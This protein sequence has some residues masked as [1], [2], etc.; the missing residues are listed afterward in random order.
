MG[1][2]V[3]SID[4]TARKTISHEVTIKDEITLNCHELK[5][6]NFLTLNARRLKLFVCRETA[7]TG[8]LTIF[9]QHATLNI[10]RNSV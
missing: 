2:A 10:I 5:L 6:R 3:L 4:I 1:T 9:V 8:L 7:I